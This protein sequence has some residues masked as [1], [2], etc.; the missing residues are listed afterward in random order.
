[1]SG[2]MGTASRVWLLVCLFFASTAPG[3]TIYVD[4][5]A[6]G[7]DDGSSWTNAYRCLQDA[8]ADA[9]AVRG[10][11]EIR[12]AQGVYRPDSDAIH[13][14]G[15]RDRSASFWLLDG[16]ALMGGFGGVTAP[17][18]DARDIALYE[19]ILSGDLAG[20][21]GVVLDPCDLLT[22]PTR[23]ENSRAIV[24]AGPCSRAAVL[25]GFTICGGNGMREG[26]WLDEMG[27]G[28][29][30]SYY[31]ADCCPSVRNCT[32]A[33]NCALVGGAA[34]VIGARPEFV[35]C[36]FVGNAA[37]DGGA[38]STSMWRDGPW[39]V[40]ACD[41][42]IRDC[43]FADNYAR[44]WG[45]ALDV[46]AG[47]PFTLEGCTFTR[48]KSGDR[49]GAICNAQSISL[50]N[51]LL[52]HN[53]A[54]RGGGAV[55]S[56]GRA[57]DIFSCTF[58]GNTA[59]A[60]WALT[61]FTPRT[62]VTNSILWDDGSEQSGEIE[63]GAITGLDV[64]YSDIRGGWPPGEGNTD[65]DPLFAGPGHW[66]RGRWYDG[67]YHLKS[68][69]GRWD[70]VN[71][72]WVA[73]DVTS[74]CIDAGD[75]YSPVRDEPVP[76]G[77]RIN[78]GVYGGTPEASKSPASGPTAGLWSEPVPLAEVNLDT[79]EE[80]SP[81]LSADGLTLYFGRVNRPE[82]YWARIFQATRSSREPYSRFTSVTE[83][84]GSLNQSVEH[85]ICPWI[86]ADGRRMYYTHQVGSVF[87]LMVSE[88]PAG[89][90]GWPM[91]TEI[92][93]LNQLNPRLHTAR[94]TADELTIFFAGPDQQGAGAEYDIWMA[95]R[96]SRDGPFI[97][98]AP[99]TELNSPAN[100]L[101]ATPSTDGL[102][103]YFASNRSGRY[104]LFRATREGRRASFGPPV[105][106]AFFDT[107]GGHTMFPYLSPDGKEFY[108][109]RQRGE[110]RSARDIWVS[111]R[112]D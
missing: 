95:T 55:Y 101:Q 45:G 34:F 98:P 69:A 71:K 74:P 52:I 9:N 53:V 106:L 92:S 84:P 77:G 72:R 10:P 87:R 8:L 6:A 83:L 100:D 7:A 31:G 105:H 2:S 49:G 79:A 47:E 28:L 24:T 48:N 85:V 112:L 23:A 29:L 81:V 35:Y 32:F 51:C 67:D 37:S 107:P 80:W 56:S 75:P 19:T 20:D 94:L 65:A 68:Q 50:V 102:S 88:R 13:P 58:S 43:V 22:E 90:T 30:L 82:S 70:P 33:G 91:G 54:A 4:D 93:E 15:T 39:F 42:V 104:Q 111:Y 5:D 99:M 60:G 25:D 41:L 40:S 64:T 61:S 38:M 97:E 16:V 18:P 108:F 109:M 62:T 89:A 110:N 86:S 78:M 12:V 26:C 17:D 3:G 44:S 1:M 36:T 63:I 76:N 96:P 14:E 46:G 27:G 66:S 57:L 21:D 103:L 11:M 59:P 73:D